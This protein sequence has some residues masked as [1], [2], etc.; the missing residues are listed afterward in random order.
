MNNPQ[1]GFLKG[2][3][4]IAAV[5]E[6]LLNHDEEF[7]Y[8]GLRTLLNEIE[9]Q[10][11]DDPSSAFT[12]NDSGYATLVTPDRNYDAGFFQTPS[13]SELRQKVAP[14]GSGAPARLSLLLGADSLFDI[15]TLQAGCGD[16][17]LFQ[18]A[19]QF[20]CLEAPSSYIVPVAN[21]L[22][23][24]TQGPRASISA[25]P[26]TFLRHYAAPRNDDTFVQGQGDQIDLLGDVL[27]PE[28]AH[29][30][31]GYLKSSNIKDLDALL[32][33][34]EQGFE[35][36]RVGVHDGVEVVC[37]YDWAGPVPSPAPR[38]GQVFTS[39][40][41]LGGYSSWQQDLKVLCRPLLRAAYLGTLLAALS[42]NRQQ[43]ILTLIGGGVFGN[44]L[45][46]IWD[47]IIWAL[48]ETDGLASRPL[49]VVVNMR[50]G[51]KNLSSKDVC[52]A[53]KK[54]SGT[55]IE[56][57]GHQLRVHSL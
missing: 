57:S 26:G 13:L 53:V 12:F 34:L 36:I 30:Q 47:A 27:D 21:Y 24:P 8:K 15:G 11:S 9:N 33:L 35:D 32:S 39:T 46:E 10:V 4:N 55:I 54:R 20:N 44:P 22:Q 16:Q 18:A 52:R 3:V 42:L 6:E 51:L 29:V 48:E 19:S 28:V 40:I 43:V 41:A 38:I 17:A 7:R 5:R 56:S 37:G 1:A 25:F 45:E 23:D 49:D 14:S 31:A 50:D 2:L